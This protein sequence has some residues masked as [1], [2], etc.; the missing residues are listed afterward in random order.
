MDPYTNPDQQSDAT[1]HAMVTRLEER[2]NH[3]VFRSFIADYAGTLTREQPLRVLE[4]GCGTGAVLR[5]VQAF[6]HPDSELHGV[7]ISAKL[8]SAAREHSPGSNIQWSQTSSSLPYPEG[9]F[10]VVLMH[11]LLGHVPDTGRMLEEASRVLRQNAR[12]IIFEADH[13]ATTFALPDYA[14]MREAD[15]KLVSAIATHPDICRQMPR[16]LK[17]AGFRI[18]HHKAHPLSECPKGDFWL[19]SVKGFARLIPALGILSKEEGEEWVEQMLRSHEEGTFF[20][21]GVFYTFQA[22]KEA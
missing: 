17:A 5:Q 2:A 4:I 16:H 14:R 18:D 9:Y 13:A 3:S 6:L 19:S 1:I 7:D 10:D 12:L 11:T 22:V 15:H 21:A 20:A 8:L